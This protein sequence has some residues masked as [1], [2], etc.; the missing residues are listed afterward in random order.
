MK[1]VLADVG[2]QGLVLEFF[3]YFQHLGWMFG[4]QEITDHLVKSVI[5]LFWQNSQNLLNLSKCCGS[6]SQI[7]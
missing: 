1:N 4:C 3:C 6:V 2:K 5:V 7:F